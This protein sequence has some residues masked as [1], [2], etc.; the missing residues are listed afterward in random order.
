MPQRTLEISGHSV[1]VSN[2]DKPLYPKDDFTKG[3]VLAYLQAVGEVMVPH[4]RDRPL[5]MRR[6][7]DG[8]EGEGF[9]QKGASDYFPAW[10]ETADIPQRSGRKPVR[11]VVCNNE[12][13]LA[14]VANQ[15]CLEFHVGLSRVNNLEHPDRFVVDVDPPDGVDVADLRQA[16]RQIRD[17]FTAVGFTPFVQATGGKGFHV[18]ACLDESADY[19]EVRTFARDLARYLADRA[20]DELTFEQRKDKRGQRI[21]LDVN[22]NA[23][24]QTVIAPY[25]LRSHP[26]VPVATP[27]DWSELGKVEPDSYHPDGIRRRLSRKDDPWAELARHAGSAVDARGRLEELSGTGG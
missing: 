18:V 15:A 2:L 20:P 4:L 25:S 5:T 7:P 21:F 8:I 19:D 16:V 10:V 23:Y 6:F 11:H 1:D 12:A 17:V 27:I 22:R 24:G 26:G 13:T 9:I 3:D 14:Y